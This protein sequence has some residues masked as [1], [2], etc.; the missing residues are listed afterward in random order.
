MEILRKGLI[1][2]G[3]GTRFG[4]SDMFS[5]AALER[6][7]GEIVARHCGRADARMVDEQAQEPGCRV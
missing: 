6:V 4:S 3:L 1:K 7:M 5:A 2:K